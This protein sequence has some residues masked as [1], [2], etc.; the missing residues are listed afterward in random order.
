[1]AM[2]KLHDEIDKALK[3]NANKYETKDDWVQLSLK[4]AFEIVE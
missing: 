4:E 2:K 3:A 1:M